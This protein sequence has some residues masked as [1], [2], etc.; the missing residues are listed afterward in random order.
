MKCLKILD[1]LSFQPTLLVDTHK[2]YKTKLTIILQIIFIIL[3]IFGVTY[4]SLDI[5][6][7]TN[8][9]IIQSTNMVQDPPRKQVTPKDFNIIISL[10]HPV[11]YHPYRDESIYTVE[12]YKTKLENNRLA[13]SERIKTEVCSQEH[14]KGVDLSIFPLN[15]NFSDYYC[16]DKDAV[17]EIEGTLT[18]KE[19]LYYKAY[20]RMCDPETSK[21]NCASKEEMDFYL[22][23]AIVTL[24]H[25]DLR[26]DHSDYSNPG[27]SYFNDYWVRISKK[28]YT[29]AV[30]HFK[31]VTFINNIGVLFDVNETK[32][33]LA[34]DDITINKDF[35]PYSY[36]FEATFSYGQTNAIVNRKYKKIQ[37]VISE[38]GGL[39]NFLYLFSTFFIKYVTEK[40]FYNHLV[41]TIFGQPNMVSSNSGM[42]NSSL[43]IINRE[44]QNVANDLNNTS[45]NNH[46][47]NSDNIVSKEQRQRAIKSIKD[48]LE[49]AELLKR[50]KE[51]KLLQLLLFNRDG[52]NTFKDIID[53]KHSSSLLMLDYN[54]DSVLTMLSS[55][56]N[57]IIER[58]EIINNYLNIYG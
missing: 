5:I 3:M 27:I 28:Y 57:S 9:N 48:N 17:L 55:Q 25:T 30:F 42:P 14:F 35:Q 56:Q 52:L 15:F 19:K 32:E 41:R 33:Y 4:F 24:Y 8:P 7:R 39:L 51:L 29:G 38:I 20:I 2:R 11:L 12:F 10:N 50:F 54:I 26:F 1:N 36:M 46:I 43:L 22:D 49:V 47:N 40:M 58:L 18:S 13:G 23:G 21:V 45:I 6:N 53:S 31:I 34:V 37:N 44:N 16:I